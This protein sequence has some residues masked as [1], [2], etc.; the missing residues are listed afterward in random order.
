MPLGRLAAIA[1]LAFLVVVITATSALASTFLRR[2]PGNTVL[3]AGSVITSTGG[4]FTTAVTGFGE[5]TCSAGFAATIGSSGT[6]SVTGTLNSFTFGGCRYVFVYLNNCQV[7]SP[8]PSITVTATASG[9]TMTWSNASMRCPVS[10]SPPGAC[11]Y[12]LSALTST[13][14]NPTS[15]LRFSNSVMFHTVPAGSTDDVGAPCAAG[16][17][18][19]SMDFRD[20]HT[21]GGATV[22]V[23][24]S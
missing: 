14:L 3:A 15:T 16:G 1:T 12:Q 6:A 5:S 20:V 17:S 7:R 24:M 22:T 13:F 2:D 23:T 10:T 8:A 18:S 4:T 11:Y 19:F 21:S 9:A